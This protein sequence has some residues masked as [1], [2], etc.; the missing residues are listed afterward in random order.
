MTPDDYQTP[1]LT[2]GLTPDSYLT[3]LSMAYGTSYPTTPTPLYAGDDLHPFIMATDVT[4][5]RYK[6]VS[7]L[8]EAQQSYKQ[9]KTQVTPHYCS[10]SVLRLVS[11]LL[12]S[13]YPSLLLT[14][15][16]APRLL[17]LSISLPSSP[18]LSVSSSLLSTD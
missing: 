9:H 2:P 7:L 1:Y 18:Y 16:L 14:F 17:S 11:S 4:A 6:Q 12:P 15:C 8:D 13:S 3:P 5:A 10:P